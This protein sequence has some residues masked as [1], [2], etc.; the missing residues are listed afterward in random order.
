L[1]TF[2]EHQGQIREA[3]VPRARSTPSREILRNL[4][5]ELIFIENEAHAAEEV[6]RLCQSTGTL[7][8]T[9]RQHRAGVP[10]RAVADRDH[11]DGHRSKSSPRWK[12]PLR[13]THSGQ[14]CAFSRSRVKLVDRMVALVID[15]RRVPL[16]SPVLDPN[17]AL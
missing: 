7:G 13:S 11:E 9:Q 17:L 12:R 4:G 10:A 3:L 2:N 6:R 8:S 14:R 1:G 16:T 5:V 15:L